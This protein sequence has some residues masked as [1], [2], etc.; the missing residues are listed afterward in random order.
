MVF[1]PWAANK[2]DCIKE[3]N[4]SED[5]IT[6][7]EAKKRLSKY[8]EN[9]IKKEKHDSPLRIFFSQFK[10]ALVLILIAAT[11]VSY[12]IGDVVEAVVI[13]T[14]VLFNAIVGF[15]QEYKAEKSIEALRKLT[16]LKVNV[17][18]NGK[19]KEIDKKHVVPGDIIILE[20]GSKVPADCRI[21][22]N[23]EL[24]SDESSLTGESLPISKKID[25]LKEDT[26]LADRKNMLFAGTSIVRGRGK[27]IV[28]ETGSNT[29]IGKIAKS[30]QQP[31]PPTPLQKYLDSFGKKIGLVTLAII[32]FI[33]L[34]EF[35]LGTGDTVELF[36]TAISLGVAAVPEGLPA[37]VTLTASFGVNRMAEKKALVRRL[38]AVEALGSVNV[39]CTDKTGTLTEN[40]MIV[41]SAYANNEE[42]NVK[43]CKSDDLFRCG[44][45]CNNAT[46]NS[47]DPTEKALISS[48][49]EYGILKE[50]TDWKRIK[51]IPFSSE[52]KRMTVIAKR[53][54]KTRVF[55]K[56]SPEIVLDR[57]TK[58][59]IGDKT[60][61]L[62]KKDK[63]E[64]KEAVDDMARN[65]LRVLGFAY[66]K[67]EKDPEEGLTFIG[68]QGMMDPP[69]DEIKDAIKKCETAGIRVVMITGDYAL[70][71]KAVSEKIGLVADGTITGKEINSM[72]KDEFREA[73]R[74]CNIFARVDP[75][76][77][78]NIVKELRRQGYV[79]AVTGDGVNDAP[80]LKNSDIGV[81]MGQ[82]GTDVAK[83]A[84]DMVITDDNFAT[85]VNAV[86]EG[87]RIFDNIKKFINYLL[88]AN[89]GEV[90]VILLAAV[91][92]LPLPIIAVQIL[93]INLIT[94]GFP[95]LALGLDPARPGI[96]KK[97]EEHNIMD[98]KMISGIIQTGIIVGLASLAVFYYTLRSGASLATAQTMVF[99]AIVLIEFFRIEV[100][101]REYGEN[102]W[103]NKWLFIAIIFSFLLHLVVIYTPL[104]AYFGTEPLSLANWGV[105]GLML[106]VAGALNLGISRYIHRNEKKVSI[107]NDL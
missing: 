8:G 68:L 77:K 74:N 46:E 42:T 20:E 28:V 2:D 5:G 49:K 54:R 9:E 92:F 75:E 45:L 67:G 64:I 53:G 4:S 30:I 96:M 100:I 88:S 7:A 31:N 95:A 32:V 60:R 22:E 80:A 87:R 21:I 34:I 79:T 70:T 66:K 10:N 12:F 73:V 50:K 98:K 19:E 105:L 23:I 57:C 71:A 26:S 65:A 43:G 90:L 78:M 93:W 36:I 56:G 63:K 16:A 84:S 102:I 62:T 85:I 15:L 58:I 25:K 83:E 81:S 38:S 106:T 39:I 94:D 48:A 41:Q 55:M 52:T 101:E 17:L 27:A 72:R 14:I 76:H 3:L 29:E 91:F 99:T 44:M 40:K 82:R 97:R 33:F 51:E 1:K 89:L 18:R 104:N 37:V 107:R 24:K 59:K 103:S 86:E 13:L 11:I 47:G 6:E 69:R 35:F 61:K